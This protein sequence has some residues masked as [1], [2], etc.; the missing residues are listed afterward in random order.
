MRRALAE[1][2]RGRGRRR[3]EPDGR[4]GG[5]PR[6]PGG[7]SRPSRPVR[8]PARRGRRA[9]GRRRGGAGGDALRHARTLLPPRQDPP[10]H[11]R[12]D[13]GRASRRVVAAMGDPFPK[14][15]GG[16]LRAAGRGRASP[17]RS[18]CWPTRRV[19]S[20][21]PTSSGSRRAGR[22]VTAKW[23]M[24]LDGKIAARPRATAAGSRARGRGRWSTRSAG[25]WTRS[26]SGSAPP[27]P[28]TPSS[29][30]ARPGPGSP[31]RVVL[32]SL[33]PAAAA[34]PA[35]PTAR[36]IPVW[37]RR[38]RSAPAERVARPP[39]PRLRDPRRSPS[40]PRSRSFRALLD[41][42]GRR[43][44]TNLLVEGGGRVLGAFLDAGRGRRGRRLHRPD[45]RG[46]VARL[47]SR[48]GA[49]RRAIAEALRLDRPSVSRVDGDVRIQ[50][51]LIPARA[52]ECA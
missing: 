34:E 40:R 28:T 39:R 9:R 7:R 24:T 44:M 45:H 14:V 35:R 13:P 20:T 42:L 8:R 48:A 52:C 49:R 16:G 37:R 15:A 50:G 30:P 33:G 47:H 23:A 43:G 25:G 46:R 41:E 21:P 1:A 32:D 26:W 27:W 4:S 18:A 36:E 17:S 51:P 12:P 10:L 31:T 11:R 6:R 22:Y 2:E 5:R 19:G 38:D 29:P 3:T